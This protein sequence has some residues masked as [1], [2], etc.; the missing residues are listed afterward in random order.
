MEELRK[1]VYLQP[2]QDGFN[3][4]RSIY[5]DIMEDKIREGRQGIEQERYL[6]VVIERKDF[7]E[8]IPCAPVSG[9]RFVRTGS[10]MPEA[11]AAPRAGISRVLER[12]PGRKFSGK[13]TN[14]L[15]PGKTLKQ[16][17]PAAAGTAGMAGGGTNNSAAG[18]PAGRGTAG[19]GMKNS[20]RNRMVQLFI[21]RQL[22]EENQESTGQ[23][24][25]DAVMPDFSAVVKHAAGYAGLFLAGIFLLTVLL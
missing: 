1:Y 4:Y 25:K 8:A 3:H 17:N 2:E 15:I 7:E 10:G 5:N 13:K 6:T 18:K 19:Q 9:K 21:S 12:K 23:M 22:Q 11:A 14:I 24:L 20:V 16:K